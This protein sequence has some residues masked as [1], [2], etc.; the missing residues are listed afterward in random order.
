MIWV[1]GLLFHSC[2]FDAPPP[3]SF[4]HHCIRLFSPFALHVA[5][6][7]LFIQLLPISL[8]L[9]STSGSLFLY[10]Q[11]PALILCDFTFH[12]EGPSDSLAAHLLT[13]TSSANLQPR[14]ALIVHLK[15]WSLPSIALSLISVAEFSLSSHHLVSFSIAHQP[16][17]SH[18]V[19]WPFCHF[20]SPSTLMTPCLLSALS[21]LSS[22]DMVVNTLYSSFSSTLESFAQ[23]FN[24]K[25]HPSLAP[26]SPSFSPPPA[27]KSSFLCSCG[28][29]A[30]LL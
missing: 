16:P 20:F 27:P 30:E 3:P 8:P 4:K 2:C 19:T 6:H 11:S 26:P 5:C 29:A 25:V 22:V 13:L 23:L 1:I 7:L 24:H 14:S 10:S 21:S 15:T 18:L 28:H 17:S 9:I 12:V